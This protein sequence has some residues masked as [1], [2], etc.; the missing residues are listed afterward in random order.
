M[1]KKHKNESARGSSYGLYPLAIKHGQL[2]NLSLSS[3]TFPLK[4]PFIGDF[5]ASHA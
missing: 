2:K 3:M 4:P 1:L 5:P